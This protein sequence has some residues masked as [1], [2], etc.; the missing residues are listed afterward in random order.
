M[1][2]SP[3]WRSPRQR[4]QVSL[5]VTI[6]KCTHWR[7]CI[8][9]RPSRK[10]SL[11]KERRLKYTHWCPF[12][13][14]RPAVVLLEGLSEGLDFASSFLQQGVNEVPTKR[15][16]RSWVCYSATD[17]LHVKFQILILDNS[18]HKFSSR[19]HCDNLNGKSP[20]LTCTLEC[21][22]SQLVV[23]FLIAL[24][25]FGMWSHSGKQAAKARPWGWCQSCSQVCLCCQSATNMS[26][27]SARI[28]HWPRS[29][30]AHAFSAV[31]G[32]SHSNQLMVFWVLRRSGP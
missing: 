8:D 16:H 7:L 18:L 32:H 14:I 30:R 22:G 11:W 3:C 13:P 24:L 29:S 17:P 5:W 31:T 20:L 9:L 1:R 15:E 25:I 12:S 19:A 27:V 23:S 28:S 4:D 2:Q 21:P 6:G 10:F 26:W